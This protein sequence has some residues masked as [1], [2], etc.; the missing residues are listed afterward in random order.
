MSFQSSQTTIERR[1]A[2]AKWRIKL[3]RAFDGSR[4][5]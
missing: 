4:M 1:L 2:K 5:L 3:E